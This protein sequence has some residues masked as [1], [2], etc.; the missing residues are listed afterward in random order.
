MHR[1]HS[2]I[3][4]A[5]GLG[6]T[7]L[8]PLDN[9]MQSFVTPKRLQGLALRCE[10]G[11]RAQLVPVDEV[12]TITRV[13]AHTAVERPLVADRWPIIFRVR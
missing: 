10:L 9:A 13:A 1:F 12:M 3:A 2:L 7:E 5:A 6:I 11:R 4:L 8:L